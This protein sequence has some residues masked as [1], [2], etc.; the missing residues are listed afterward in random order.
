MGIL[1]L[2]CSSSKQAQQS[3]PAASDT[4]DAP[5]TD[6]KA[7]S[8]E[9]NN[10]QTEALKEKYRE[11]LRDD[12][13][14]RANELTTFYILA[15]RQ[16]YNGNYQN[17]LSTVNKAINTKENADLLALRGSIYLRLGDINNFE[18]DWRRALTMDEDVPL[19]LSEFV[20]NKLI[21]SGLINENLERNF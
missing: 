13:Q 17:A 19:P 9:E 14:T 16:F 1:P 3:T 20:K 11:Q 4:T 21:E 12:Y 10:E 7:T 5:E 18:E 2:A 8:S 15:Q 6:T